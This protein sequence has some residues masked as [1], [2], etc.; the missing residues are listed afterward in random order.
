MTEVL[1][2]TVEKY[3]FRMDE[4]ECAMLECSFM[5]NHVSY[6]LISRDMA[7]GVA[8]S[9]YAAY[10]TGEQ[11]ILIKLLFSGIKMSKLR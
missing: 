7:D 4:Y 10:L 11:A 3:Y 2:D 9:L 8:S 5:E 6:S 1:E